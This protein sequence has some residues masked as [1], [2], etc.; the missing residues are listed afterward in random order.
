MPT[1]EIVPDT[2]GPLTEWTVIGGTGTHESAIDEAR[3][4][5]NTADRIHGDQPSGDDNVIDMFEMSTFTMGGTITQIE[6]FAYCQGAATYGGNAEI[7][8]LDIF[9]SGWQG[10]QYLNPGTGAYAWKSVTFAGLNM[11]Q[12]DLNSC[13][14]RIRAD[15]AISKTGID[16][17]CVYAVVTYTVGYGHD[18]LGVPAANIDNVIGVPTENIDKIIGV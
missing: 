17:A 12:A 5:P 6:V 15:L 4:S 1:G 13:A 8:F 10:Y 9:G 2:D 18:F 11:N 3:A 14:I 16:I 7:D